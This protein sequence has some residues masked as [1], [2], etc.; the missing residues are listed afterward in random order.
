MRLK[1]FLMGLVVLALLMVGACVYLSQMPRF[2]E[3]AITQGLNKQPGVHV[4]QLSIRRA[5]S[6][7]AS[8]VL[9]EINGRIKV[10]GESFYISVSQ[11][12]LD[13]WMTLLT[14][15]QPMRVGA[16]HIAIVSDQINASD[17]KL[18]VAVVFKAFNVDTATG[19]VFVKML[20][21][22][23]YELTDLVLP[24]S[25]R[26]NSLE[27][28]SWVGAL[29]HGAIKGNITFEP[30]LVG[31]YSMDIQ[32]TG[33]DTTELAKVN[34][35]VFGQYK[36]VVDGGMQITGN[37]TKIISASGRFVAPLG[38]VMKARLLGYIA[39]YV[40]QR[41]SLERLMSTDADIPIN[42]SELVLN[43][44]SDEQWQAQV[45]LL[46][47]DVNLDLNLDFDI[48]IDGGSVG[49]YNAAHRLLTGD[50]K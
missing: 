49:L 33:V 37:S 28:S 21:I 39:Q 10:N 44:I 12:S 4:S 38:G 47:K 11:L 45:K 14:S 32:L 23:Q 34:N 26:N 48:N 40:P 30:A 1:I 8:I 29:A 42:I 6:S 13:H 20:N 19:K 2:W 25:W 3:Y 7:L 36:A 18:D 24:I 15:K 41:Q 27:I 17:I 35:D 46:S 50:L 43:A 31:R 22:E 5:Q 16:D 9:N